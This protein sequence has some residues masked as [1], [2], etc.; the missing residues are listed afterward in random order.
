MQA[1]RVRKSKKGQKITSLNSKEKQVEIMWIN[2]MGSGT[3]ALT[4]Y[5]DYS[6]TLL[7]I[8]QDTERA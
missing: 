8:F 6:V 3:S 1:Y 7:C 2:N 5:Q 4:I